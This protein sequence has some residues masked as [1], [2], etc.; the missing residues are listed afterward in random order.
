[1]SWK[2]KPLDDHRSPDH[3]LDALALSNERTYAAWIRTGLSALVAGVAIEK[4]IV[5][6]LPGW[7]IRAIAIILIALSGAFFGL[8]G[9]RFAHL[10]IRLEAASIRTIPA[11]LTTV[12]SLLLV[13]CSLLA[14]VGLWLVETKS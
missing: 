6:V 12:L 9:W 8:A 2:L 4:F 7:G 14:L 11:W 1:M 3:S 5:E 13:A 10:G